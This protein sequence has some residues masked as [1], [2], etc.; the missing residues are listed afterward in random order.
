VTPRH[1]VGVGIKESI[2]SLALAFPM[3]SGHIEPVVMIGMIY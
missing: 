2:F 1:S 3:K